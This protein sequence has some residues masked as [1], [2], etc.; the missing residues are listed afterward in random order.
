MCCGGWGEPPF[1]G[2]LNHTQQ[3]AAVRARLQELRRRETKEAAA[4]ARE[5]YLAALNA[6]PDDHRLHES[7]AEFLEGT[8]A[9]DEAAAEWRRL[10]E[11]I[12]QHHVAWF[13]EGRLLKQRGK[14]AEAEPLLSQAV[15]LR[16]DLAEGW[17][18]LGI[19]HATQS[20]T[21]QALGDYE[22]ERRLMPNDSPGLLPYGQ[23]A[24]EIAPANR[25]H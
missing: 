14:L 23:G 19:L 12:P 6:S 8:G 25:R 21:E 9:L 13:Q 17:L 2:Q 24:I 7:F 11:V 16:S 15:T 3:V 22:R 5:V 1:V 18:E 10:R 4:Q 20:K